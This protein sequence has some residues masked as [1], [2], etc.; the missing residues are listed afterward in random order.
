M[1]GAKFTV[2]YDRVC[3]SLQHRG[4]AGDA[5]YHRLRRWII[6]L[7]EQGLVDVLQGVIDPLSVELHQKKGLYVRGR[8]SAL[9]LIKGMQNSKDLCTGIKGPQ[10][11]A[12]G[13][14][15]LCSWMFPARCSHIRRRAIAKAYRIN[16]YPLFVRPRPDTLNPKLVEKIDEIQNLYDQWVED[17]EDKQIVLRRVRGDGNPYC[18]LPMKTRF[19]DEGRMVE[20]LKTYE[21]GID[22]SLKHFNKAVFLT[23]TTDPLMWMAPEGSPVERTIKDKSGKELC[24]FQVQGKGASL[25]E[26][27]RHESVAWRGWYEVETHHRKLRLPYIRVVEFMENGLIH[28]HILLFGIDWIKDFKQLAYEWGVRYG[29]GFMVHA[30]TIRKRDGMWKWKDSKSTP[31]DAA[32]KDP[33]DYL[34]KYLK[35]ALY[36]QDGFFGYWVHNKRFFTMS[37]SL[38]YENLTEQAAAKAREVKKAPSEYEFLGAYPSDYIP[39]VLRRSEKRNPTPAYEWGDVRPDTWWA[40]NPYR[41]GAPPAFV[42]ASTLPRGPPPGS[43]PPPLAASGGTERLPAGL[44][45][46]DFM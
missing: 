2:V 20:H 3:R 18:V 33:A 23:L 44:S 11:S 8:P 14:Y 37:Q 29:Q 27:N 36:S 24:R 5:L 1:G 32:G 41:P 43:P 25:Y 15:R 19:T 34:K 7:G 21:H 45:L 38:R 39:D 35:K 28:T 22:N 9:N 30:Y 10:K 12:D 46:A 13:D 31:D 42:P 17:T 16:Y 26:A 4:K 6:A 40:D